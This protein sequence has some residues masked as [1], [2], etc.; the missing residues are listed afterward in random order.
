MEGGIQAEGVQESS[1]EDEIWTQ[2]GQGNRG[3]EKTS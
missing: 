2:E 1:I 3:V